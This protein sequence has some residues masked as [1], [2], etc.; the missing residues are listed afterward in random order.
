MIAAQGLPIDQSP[1][2][3]FSGHRVRARRSR[4]SPIAASLISTSVIDFVVLRLPGL[5]DRPSNF[6]SP[7]GV[8]FG[9][10]GADEVVLANRPVDRK[11]GEAS[12]RSG[13]WPER[14]RR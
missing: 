2:G 7:H 5:E 9:L 4:R 12:S 10:G 3:S 13:A 14:G 6:G 8:V 1:T 11:R